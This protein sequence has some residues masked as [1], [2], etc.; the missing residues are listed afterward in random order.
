LLQV[1][2]GDIMC[3]YGNYGPYKQ[4]W[5]CFG[6]RK[7]FRNHR[8][9]APVRALKCP[10]CKSPMRDMGRDFKAPRTSELAQWKKVEVLF[11]AGFKYW[12]CGCSG[13][14][15]RPKYLREVPEFLRE[16]ER[17]DAELAQRQRNA[18]RAEALRLKRRAAQKTRAKKRVLRE[19]AG[20]QAST[21]SQP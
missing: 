13:P 1:L 18:S 7:M 14:G 3:R 15:E 8:G 17:L 10:E 2:G 11:R 20:L 6:C 19:E 4:H 12:S 16:H 9:E 21:C 5:A